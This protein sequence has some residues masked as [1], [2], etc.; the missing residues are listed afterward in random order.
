MKT[1]FFIITLLVPTFNWAANGDSSR[2]FVKIQLGQRT[3]DA[4]EA[5]ILQTIE[6]NQG[7]LVALHYP[8]AEVVNAVKISG[9][10]GAVLLLTKSLD[11]TIILQTESL[12]RG[13]YQIEISSGNQKISRKLVVL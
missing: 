12:T 1:W 8:Q 4:A 2:V 13:A 3:I 11:K 9:A 6:L 5:Q 7:K 10:D